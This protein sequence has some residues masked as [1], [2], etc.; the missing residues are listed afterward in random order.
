MVLQHVTN[1][2]FQIGLESECQE[3]DDD[4]LS[5]TG[6][7]ETTTFTADTITNDKLL[8]EDEEV[9]SPETLSSFEPDSSKPTN[10]NTKLGGDPLMLEILKKIS[11]ENLLKPVREKLELIKDYLLHLNHPNYGGVQFLSPQQIWEKVHEA[12]SHFLTG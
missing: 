8:L 7:L 10:I 11:P 2:K 12:G 6:S 1:I 4:P 9:L 3:S 5:T